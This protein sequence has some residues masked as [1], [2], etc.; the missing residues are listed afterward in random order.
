MALPPDAE[1]AMDQ[2]KTTSERRPRG[3]ALL[4]TAERAEQGESDKPD[5]RLERW[6]DTCTHRHR[7]IHTEKERGEGKK[8]RRK[9]NIRRGKHLEGTGKTL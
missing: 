2:S 3:A 1:L 7:H 6:A 4:K 9:H 8:R 5:S